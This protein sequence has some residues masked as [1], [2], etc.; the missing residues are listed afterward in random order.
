MK[1]KD[2]KNFYFVR[3]VAFFCKGS[4]NI[5]D[6]NYLWLKPYKLN[7][8]NYRAL[9]NKLI[10]DP[11]IEISFTDSELIMDPLL[12]NQRLYVSLQCSIVYSNHKYLGSLNISTN[13]PRTDTITVGYKGID[14]RYPLDNIKI[15]K[16]ITLKLCNE[17]LEEYED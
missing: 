15:L 14:K 6:S 3:N 5:F 17:C 12:I 11:K 1:C 4:T 2:L 13:E 7:I 10:K 16:E 8:T 9:V